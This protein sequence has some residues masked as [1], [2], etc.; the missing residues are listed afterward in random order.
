MNFLASRLAFS[1]AHPFSAI[2]QSRS[3]AKFPMGLNTRLLTF[4]PTCTGG[5]GGD[6]RDG[7]R[8]GVKEGLLR[9]TIEGEEREGEE[10]EGG[11][12]LFALWCP[13]SC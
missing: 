7:N 4:C 2:A 1:I 6:N 10:G 3:G 13:L 12:T 5:V 9:E 8:E 11:V